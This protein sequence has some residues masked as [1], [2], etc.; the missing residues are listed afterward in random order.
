MAAD[1][2]HWAAHHRRREIYV[3][4][5]T[6]YTVLGNKIAPWLAERYLARTAV[7]G[8]QTEQPPDRL[9]VEG[10]VFK[11]ADEDPGARG[12]RSDRAHSRSPQWFLSRHR[13]ALL[14]GLAGAA[15]AGAALLARR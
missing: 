6:V 2:V 14:G 12:P 1:A 8:Q 10:N 3:G 7:T 13:L 15:G 9:N 11:T 5:P 4:I